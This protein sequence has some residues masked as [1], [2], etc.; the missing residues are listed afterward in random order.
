MKYEI[1]LLGTLAPVVHA[2]LKLFLDT[3]VKKYV[4]NAKTILLSGK[5]TLESST[6]MGAELRRTFLT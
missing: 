1:F 6:F 2:C 3:G 4:K 5:T